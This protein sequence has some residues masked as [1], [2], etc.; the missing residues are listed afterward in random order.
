MT[1][2]IISIAHESL[3]PLQLLDLELV[4]INPLHCVHFKTYLSDSC[5][6]FPHSYN[7]ILQRD[8]LWQIL[9]DS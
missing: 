8:Q 7:S 6:P 9:N 5:F 2:I 1:I 4:R 3:D